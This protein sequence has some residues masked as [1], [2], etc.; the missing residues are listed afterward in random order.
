M[1]D[2]DFNPYASKPKNIKKE[3]VIEEVK[4]TEIDNDKDEEAEAIADKEVLTEEIHY[5]SKCGAKVTGRFCSAC[6]Y[7]TLYGYSDSVKTKKNV[8]KTLKKKNSFLSFVL[9][10]IIALPILF[11][12]YVLL[13]ESDNTNYQDID[14]GQ[15]LEYH[16]KYN[17]Y[18][19]N[20]LPTGKI[21]VEGYVEINIDQYEIEENRFKNTISGIIVKPKEYLENF[22]VW[23]SCICAMPK[24]K[25]IYE[26]MIQAEVNQIVVLKG[27]ITG[28]SKSDMGGFFIDMLVDDIELKQIIE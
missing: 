25:E 26:K 19:M 9:G 14:L 11:S 13:P 8:K 23:Q 4:T 3:E 17:G 2:T 18:Y 5:C 28:Y 10:I 21:N 6:G 7:D 12:V 20:E 16:T 22:N 1:Y 24:N 15:M 27:K